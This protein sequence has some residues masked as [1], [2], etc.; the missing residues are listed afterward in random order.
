MPGTATIPAN[1]WSQEHSLSGSFVFVEIP[2]AG[3][4]FPPLLLLPSRLPSRLRAFAAL[5]F[6]PKSCNFGKI[7]VSIVVAS[8]CAFLEPAWGAKKEAPPATTAAPAGELAFP[9]AQGFAAYATGG[10]GGETV[11]VTTL[12]DSG[13][14]SF[15]EAVSRPHRMVVFD[16]GGY[17]ELHSALHIG[18]DITVS[19]Q[20]APGE[21]V[22]TRGEEISFS[23][24][25]N[26]IVQYMRFRQGL[27]PKEE[28]K[29]AIN[30]H[31]GSNIILDHLSIQWGRWDTVDI[32]GGSNI[33]IQYSI[34]GPGVAPQRFGCLCEAD[35]VTFSHDLWIN[36]H[37][38]NP[39]SKGRVQFVN[40]VVYNWQ[41]DAYI[42]G[43]SKG[44]NWHDI[45]GNYFIAGPESKHG[46]FARGNG[47]SQV[48]AR[49]NY[50]DDNR[51]GKLNGKLVPQSELGSVTI[52]KEPFATAP[53]DIDTAEQ[54]YE[55]VVAGVGCSLHR[56]S[57]DKLLIDDLTSLGTKG[58]IINSPDDMGG[59]GTLAATKPQ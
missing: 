7:C 31:D 40:N 41:L 26:V 6:D 47:N 38:R 23:G 57:V 8:A 44:K 43:A 48:Y 5:I 37:S 30:I 1:D 39:K 50:Y 45:I 58:K 18:S 59:F 36:N 32:T 27:A 29:S 51:D 19:G 21:G 10:H 2:T 16:V 24:S 42:E 56:D 28:R 15:R 54:A 46:P 11:H 49:D 13:A 22:G 12:A 34:I 4:S 25:K 55:R 17:I 33:T 14:G 35:G 53:I 20:T 3:G 52:L 9:G